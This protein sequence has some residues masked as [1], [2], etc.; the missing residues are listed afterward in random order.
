MGLNKERQL[1]ELYFL[2][3]KHDSKL[4]RHYPWENDL[5]KK[6]TTPYMWKND[7]TN[8]YFT[9]IEKISVL[10]VEQMNVARNF[11][12]YTVDKYWDDYWG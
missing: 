2:K 1:S 8:D 5:L 9:K 7:N 6:T 10:I 11:I 4:H 3:H 12:N